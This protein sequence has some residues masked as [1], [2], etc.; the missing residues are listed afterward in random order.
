[1]IEIPEVDSYPYP[2]L[3]ICTGYSE[4]LDRSR[5]LEFGLN[6]T[7]PVGSTNF[8]KEISILT[9]KEIDVLT[10]NA[11]ELLKECNLRSSTN[12]IPI[13]INSSECTKYIS[14]T[15]SITG[16]DVCYLV[17]PNRDFSY[18]WRRVA[19]SLTL[20][21]E[22]YDLHLRKVFKEVSTLNVASFNLGPNREIPYYF[23]RDYGNKISTLD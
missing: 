12:W 1:M 5:H 9:M 3:M 18:S 17:V 22:I 11:N 20:A 23:M 10:P 21:R 16:S 13:Q 2:S 14:I 6:S 19:S 8:E 15:K 4:L 7:P